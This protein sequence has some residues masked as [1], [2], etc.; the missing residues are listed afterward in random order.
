M[1]M[2]PAAAPEHL[3]DGPSALSDASPDSDSNPADHEHIVASLSPAPI[4][5]DELLTKFKKSQQFNLVD[6]G[7]FMMAGP[8]G[9]VV[10]KGF[11]FAALL[12][13]D[14]DAESTIPRFTSQWE[15]TNGVAEARDVALV[16]LK[17]R[18]ALKGA[19]DLVESRFND[20]S[21]AVVDKKGC[22]LVNQ[23]LNGPF[24][25]PEMSG[26]SAV[27]ALLAPIF[28]IFKVV[29]FGECP[30]FYSG[31]LEHPIK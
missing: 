9:A 4:D 16:T 15:L 17:S 2:P 8:V 1:N 5:I 20:F 10:T 24:S 11:N 22:A 23:S 21:L 28:N 26:I 6:L 25:E 18:V 14:P 19:I 3:A 12:N 31:S 13:L 30:A 7:A 27:E 29:A